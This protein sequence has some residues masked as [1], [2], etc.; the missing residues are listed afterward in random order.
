MKQLRTITDIPFSVHLMVNNPCRY[1]EALSKLSCSHIFVHVEQQVY[2]R[3]ILNMI[4]A[5]HM[6]AGIALNPISKISDYTYLLDDVDAILYMSS[7]P[8]Y[9]GDRFNQHVLDKIQDFPKRDIEIWI[10]GGIRYDAIAMLKRKYVD[11]A[12]VGRDLFK[13]SDYG[14]YIEK[15]RKG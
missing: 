10:D 13:Q 2:L 8:D 12:V 14:L 4:H 9:V 1:I 3:Y 6:K 15:F 11:C 5:H 7:E